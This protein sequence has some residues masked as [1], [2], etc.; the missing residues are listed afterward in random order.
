MSK[1]VAYFFYKFLMKI[2]LQVIFLIFISFSVLFLIIFF[3]E[4]IQENLQNHGRENFNAPIRAC[5]LH[6]WLKI[7]QQIIEKIFV[8]KTGFKNLLKLSELHVLIFNSRDASL[9]KWYC[10]INHWEP[11]VQELCPWKP[12]YFNVKTYLFRCYLGPQ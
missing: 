1:L 6:K 7:M 10:R 2:I 8:V 12:F 9:M 11:G 3:P 5:F 4:K